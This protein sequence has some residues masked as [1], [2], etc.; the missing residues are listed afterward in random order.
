[1]AKDG[2]FFSYTV[3]NNQTVHASL[4]QTGKQTQNSDQEYRR[5]EI[6]TM[7]QTGNTIKVINKTLGYLIGIFGIEKTQV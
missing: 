4:I 2:F 5:G 1:M 3:D 7:I 6:Y